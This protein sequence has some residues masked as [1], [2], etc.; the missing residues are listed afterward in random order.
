MEYTVIPSHDDLSP[1]NEV[2]LVLLV[3]KNRHDCISC[4][5]LLSQLKK[6]QN[7]IFMQQPVDT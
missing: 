3:G 6:D 4:K 1:N 5:V 2:T 7:S